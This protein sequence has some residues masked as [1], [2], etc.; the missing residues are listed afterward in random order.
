MGHPEQLPLFEFE[1]LGVL[2]ADR[3]G[4]DPVTRRGESPTLNLLW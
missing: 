3:D 4:R 2:D 1:K